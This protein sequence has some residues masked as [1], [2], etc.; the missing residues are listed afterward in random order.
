MAV[1]FIHAPSRVVGR[2]QRGTLRGD[3]QLVRLSYG[4]N[5]SALVGNCIL[6]M[7]VLEGGV[8]TR[9]GCGHHRR[10]CYGRK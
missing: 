10:I 9:A 8:V 7:G 2:R 3:S 6:V 4:V 5:V 1:G